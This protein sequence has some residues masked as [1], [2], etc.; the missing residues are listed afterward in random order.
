MSNETKVDASSLLSHIIEAY[1]EEYSA[2][3]DHYDRLNDLDLGQAHSYTAEAISLTA[4]G[5]MDDTSE[6]LWVDAVD[7]L[8]AL[9]IQAGL[10][11]FE[12]EALL[13]V[14][15]DCLNV[16]MLDE[17][18]GGESSVQATLNRAEKR[19]RLTRERMAVLIKLEKQLYKLSGKKVHPILKQ[20]V[21]AYS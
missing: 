4:T 18:L 21:C 14:I 13:E 16:H 5:S 15:N 6:S 17:I 11:L 8:S 7:A 2:Y 3:E 1:G 10:E 9:R 20:G 12:C 19:I